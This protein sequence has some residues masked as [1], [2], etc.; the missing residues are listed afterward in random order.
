MYAILGAIA[1]GVTW[2]VGSVLQKHGMSTSFPNIELKQVFRRLPE[3]LKALI[4]NWMWMLGQTCMFIGTAFYVEALGRGDIALVQPII[5]LTGVVALLIGVTVLRERVSA[6]ELGGI[7]LIV[8]GI[9]AVSA[10]A[11][12]PTSRMPGDAG[13]MVFIAST[14]LLAGAALAL[15]RFGLSAEYT[16]ALAA[17]IVFGL[18]NM[19]GKLITQRSA[20]DTG[21]AFALTDVDTIFAVLT[22]Y[23]FWVVVVCTILG[24]AF[25]QTAFA[26]GRAAVVSPLT[27]IVSNIAPLTAAVTIFGERLAP[28]QAVGIAVILAGT[29]LMAGKQAQPGAAVPHAT[30]E[31]QA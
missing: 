5:N 20:E 26:N 9:V 28:P 10:F 15:R 11:G 22:D 21:H 1:A 8:G 31:P 27:T 12:P 4:T 6:R 17:G 19:M 30:S 16:L 23:P 18:S 29:L 14:A 25:M 7:A 3:I 13:L 24:G 2:G